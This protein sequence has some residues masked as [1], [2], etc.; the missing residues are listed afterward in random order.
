MRAL[1]AA[2]LTT[3]FRRWNARKA[4]SPTC[5]HCHGAVETLQHRLWWC[6]VWAH[7]RLAAD[8]QEVRPTGPD[9]GQTG[10]VSHPAEEPAGCLPPEAGGGPGGALVWPRSEGDWEG[11]GPE[12]DVAWATCVVDVGP[13][14]P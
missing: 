13:R 1:L 3:M 5:P 11:L 8:G 6:P 14:R 2:G 10:L 9:E 7:L 4:E 12:V